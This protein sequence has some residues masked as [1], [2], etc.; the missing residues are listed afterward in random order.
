MNTRATRMSV[1]IICIAAVFVLALVVSCIVQQR[2]LNKLF[3]GPVEVCA[4]APRTFYPRAVYDLTDFTADAVGDLPASRCNENVRRKGA[5][6]LR[7][8][9]QTPGGVD[10]V[11][12]ASRLLRLRIPSV[13]RDPRPFQTLTIT[14]P[15]DGAIF[16]PNLCPPRVEWDD[17]RN[18]LWQVRVGIGKEGP[19]W[20]FVSFKRYWWF[21]AGLWRAV[22]AKAV[23]TDAWIR[24]LGTRR[25]RRA[26]IQSSQSIHFRISSDPADNVIVYRLVSP[27]FLPYKAPDTFVRDIRSFRTR[28]FL[29]GRRQYCFN[30]HTFSVKTG[31][32]AG[33]LAI[34]AR[35]LVESHY[36]LC[37]YFGV[38]DMAAQRGCK[39]RVPFDIQMSTFVAWSPDGTKLA[40]SANQRLHTVRPVTYETQMAT[41]PTS[42]IAICDL[43]R[44]SVHLVPGAS[45]PKRL[46]LLPRWTPDGKSIVFCS[47][48]TGLHPERVTYDLCVVPARGGKARPIPGASNNGKSNFYPRF[49]PNGKWFSFCQADHGVLIRPSS[50][51]W[52]MPADFSGNARRLECNA[53]YAA[54]SWHSWSSNSRWLVFASKRDDG[55]YARLYLTHI[56]DGGRASPAVRVPL[57]DDPIKTF[58]IPEFLAHDPKIKERSLYETMRVEKPAVPLEAESKK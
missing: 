25:D 11:T 47:A 21:P 48:P 45:D 55:V 57:R 28:P 1:V 12:A 58:N 37:T 54:D 6:P 15:P 14:Y 26:P 23:N 13:Y 5:S 32:A 7:A 4:V 8:G 33:M 24:V 44:D 40:V 18:D 10:A 41:E 38:Y 30:C 34:Q 52:L 51:I 27:P 16:P 39:I 22:R 19:T 50:D 49:S 53:P 31:G 29:K 36:E 42:D 35:Y 20:K 17:P 2:R 56:G 43:R 46:E 9:V 3:E